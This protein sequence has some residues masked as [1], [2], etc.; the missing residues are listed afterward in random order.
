MFSKLAVRSFD[1]LFLSQAFLF[2]TSEIAVCL[3]KYPVYD[4]MYREYSVILGFWLFFEALGWFMTNPPINYPLF[5]RL[6]C[7]SSIWCY[8]N[9]HLGTIITDLSVL[10]RNRPHSF[11]QLMV[12]GFFYRPVVTFICS[13]NAAVAR[14]KPCL[15]K[16]THSC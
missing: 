14:D 15:L 2:V 11:R 6:E 5:Y 3:Y 7:S 1:S 8:H 9:S 4:S 10:V 13:L 12:W 16:K